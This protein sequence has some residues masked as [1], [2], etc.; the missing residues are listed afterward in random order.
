L[1]TNVFEV[2]AFDVWPAIDGNEDNIGIELIRVPDMPSLLA[3]RQL[4]ATHRL[5]LC[6]LSS[7]FT[8]KIR[9]TENI[10]I[11]RRTKFLVD[12][13]I[14]NTIEDF[15]SKGS[16]LGNILEREPRLNELLDDGNF[17]DQTTPHA[18][19]LHISN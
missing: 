16:T 19:Y 3:T 17:I 15:L 13:N 6:S 10:K 1:D 5:L 12:S 2:E 9:N 7:R 14:P 4:K 8:S 18:A 11:R